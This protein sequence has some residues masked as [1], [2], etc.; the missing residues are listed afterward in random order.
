M[1]NHAN[2]NGGFG[3]QNGDENQTTAPTCSKAL[4]R[5]I[6]DAKKTT[7][8]EPALPLPPYPLLLVWEDEMRVM[9]V[10]WIARERQMFEMEMQEL[11]Y[12]LGFRF[13]SEKNSAQEVSGCIVHKHLQAYATKSMDSSWRDQEKQSGGLIRQ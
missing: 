10:L 6:H 3:N 9:M 13:S 8:Y 12:L 1:N 11:E 7:V 5:D 4:G 2:A